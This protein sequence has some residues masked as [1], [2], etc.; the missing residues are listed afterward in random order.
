[1]PSFDIVME[2]PTP[3]SFRA[4]KVEGMFD[5]PHREK[6]SVRITGR[7]PLEEIGDWS[8]GA[9]VGASGTGKSTIARHIFGSAVKG[10]AKWTGDCILDDFPE[11]MTPQEITEVLT[12]VGLSS[13]PVWLRP[14]SVLSTGQKFRADLARALSSPEKLVVFDEFTSV[15]DRT[16]AAAAS[17]AVAKYVRRKGRQFVAV[18]CHKD[19]LNWLEADWVYDTDSGEFMRGRLRRPEIKLTIYEGTLAAWPR[20]RGHH[21]L[22]SEISRSARVFLAYVDLLG[23]ERLAGFFSILP[24]M[25]MKGWRRG[26]RTVVLPDFQGLGIGNAMVEAT[27]EQLWEREGLRYRAVTS[28][29]ALIHHRL[30][31]PEMWRLVRGPSMVP[32]SANRKMYV[33]TSAGRL[34]TVWEYIPKSLRRSR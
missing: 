5:I 4:A 27:A 28:S 33:R 9:I 19:V 15:V 14:Y 22:T 8:I 21:Y 29:P 34:T 6:Q 30:R 16:V 26:H 25:G 31:H 23:Q 17:V 13:P 24:A 12:A 10:P 7:I 1:M 11:E 2:S 32:P 18:T 20:F 3:S